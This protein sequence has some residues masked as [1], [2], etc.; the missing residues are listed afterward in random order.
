MVHIVS[1]IKNES[2]K[3]NS[4]PVIRLINISQRNETIVTTSSKKC[5]Q[6]NL[7]SLALSYWCSTPHTVPRMGTLKDKSVKFTMDAIK[8]SMLSIKE[9]DSENQQSS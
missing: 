9:Q 5:Y 7:T 8:I 4:L 1:S 3:G 2:K 6:K